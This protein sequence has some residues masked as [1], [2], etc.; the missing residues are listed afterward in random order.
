MT[1]WTASLPMYNVTPEHAA[2]WRSLLSDSLAIVARASDL[3]DITIGNAPAGELMSHWRRKD[4]LLSQTCGYPYRMLGLANDV[5]LIATP[6][7]DA[8]GCEGPRYR[9]VIVV[10]AQAW[11]RGAKTLE[12]CRGLRA[13]CNGA[14]SHSGMNALRHAV[15]PLARDGRF[16]AS[17]LWTGSHAATLR[18]LTSGAAEVGAID[19]VTF[20]LLHDSHLAP[21]DGVQT[22]GMTASAPG[23]PLIASRALGEEQ[24]D[25]L[26][27]ALDAALA[28]DPERARKLRLRGFARLAGE[29]YAE[30][31]TFANTAAQY[32]YTELR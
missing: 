17:V 7:F 32:G 31:E 8:P 22:I 16:F 27:D 29:A 26:R 18:A 6:I 20:A 14:D 21:F 3:G 25:V 2:W 23:L 24:A 10:S 28:A 19:C 9:S 1:R 11:K 5:H 15:A 4:L 13:A 30:I 12:A